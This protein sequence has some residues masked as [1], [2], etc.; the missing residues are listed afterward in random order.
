MATPYDVNGKTP[1]AAWIPSLDTAG[2]GTTTLTDLVGSNN[3]TLTNMD[4]T[5]DWVADTG[6]GGVRALDFDGINDRITGVPM[7]SSSAWAVS[8]WLKM[9]ATSESANRSIFGNL[10]FNRSGFLIQ[11]RR[12]NAS[13]GN[14]LIFVYAPYT[15]IYS[16]NVFPTEKWSHVCFSYNGSAY[17]GWINGVEQ[18]TASGAFVQPSSGP[19]S[20]CGPSSG[21]FDGFYSGRLDDIRIFNQGVVLSD[22]QYLY[23]G[24]NGRGRIVR[25]GSSAAAVHFFTF[26]F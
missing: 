20:F 23:N 24:G 26:G 5:T 3:G 6:A 21:L 18:F 16:L 12:S 9:N 14:K 10:Q 17:T 11:K 15:P 8:L 1:I 2:N 25:S 22:V 7:F 4:P 19:W 13:D